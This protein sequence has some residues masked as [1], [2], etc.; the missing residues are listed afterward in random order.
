V[1]R[2]AADA[3]PDAAVSAGDR[4]AALAAVIAHSAIVF[5][6]DGSIVGPAGWGNAVAGLGR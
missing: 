3:V 4:H 6:Q 1:A 2:N 5:C